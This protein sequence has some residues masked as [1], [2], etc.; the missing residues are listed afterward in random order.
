MS[1]PYAVTSLHES[2]EHERRARMVKY[3]IAMGIRLACIGACFITPGWWLLIPASGA[4]LLPYLA[5][6]AANQV[7]RKSANHQAYQPGALVRVTDPR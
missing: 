6:V 3:S 2:P 5:V 1:Q 4:V 7:S